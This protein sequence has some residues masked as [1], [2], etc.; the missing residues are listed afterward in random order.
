MKTTFELPD[1]V[2]RE[3]K[4]MA[5]AQGQTLRQF[6]T[7]AIREKLKLLKS[8]S[9]AR[10][11]MKHFGALKGYVDELQRIDQVIEAEF[12]TVNLKDWK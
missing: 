7:D 8:Q 9:S 4:I 12:E 10:P 5:T 1:K 2:F 11:W 3:A 6:F